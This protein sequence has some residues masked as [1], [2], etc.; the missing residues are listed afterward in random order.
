MASLICRGRE[1]IEYLSLKMK[2][3]NWTSYKDQ[4]KVIVSYQWEF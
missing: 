1:R 2:W 4:D 3:R